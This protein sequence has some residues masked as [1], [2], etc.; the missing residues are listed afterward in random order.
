MSDL[1]SAVQD[2][3]LEGAS[4]QLGRWNMFRASKLGKLDAGGFAPVHLARSAKM[5]KLLIERGADI[6]QRSGDETHQRTALHFAAERG[7]FDTLHA[8]LANE[9]DVN[10]RDANGNTPLHLA[11]ANAVQPLVV[12]ALVDLGAEVDALNHADLSPILLAILAYPGEDPSEANQPVCDNLLAAIG[13]LRRQNADCSVTYEGLTPS[14]LAKQRHCPWI[15]KVGT[16]EQYKVTWQ[17]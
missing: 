3:D 8:L 10:A 15:K 1:H 5:V 11:V 17:E 4:A 14:D 9:A 2:D 6:Q 12:Q 16:G 13:I 7:D